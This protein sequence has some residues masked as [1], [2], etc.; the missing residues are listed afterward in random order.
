MPAFLVRFSVALLASAVAV[1]ATAATVDIPFTQRTLDNGLR[2]IVHEDRKAPIVAVNVWYHVGSKDEAPG[3]TGFAHLFEHLMFN[4]SE[5]YDDEYFLPFAQVG[6]TDQ[7]GTTSFDRTN[8]FQTVP[9]TALDLALW[10]ES[11]R[12]G[13]LLGAVTQEEL[14]TQRG[15]VQNEK[16]QGENEPYGRAFEYITEGVFPEGHPYSWLPIGSMEDISAASL[17]DVKTWFETYYGPN[18]AVLVIAGDVD[19]EEAFAKAEKFFGDIEPGPPLA[20]H[21]IW[22]P[23]LDGISRDV[24]ED[25]VKEARVYKVWTGPEWTNADADTLGLVASVLGSG[26]NSRLYKRLVYDDQIATGVSVSPLFLE[27]AG[28]IIVSATVSQTSSIEE[29]EAAIDEE[30]ARFIERGPT[31]EELKRVRTQS[32]ASFV[33]GVEK[34]GGFSGKS[35]ILAENAVYAGDPDFYKVSLERVEAATRESLREAA[36]R[37]MPADRQYVLEI[38]PH[39]EGLAAATEGADRSKLPLP[40]TFPTSRFDDYE[41]AELDNGLKLL[42]ARRDAVPVVQMQ[43]LLDAGYAADQFAPAGTSS[44]AMA[45]LDEGTSSRDALEISDELGQLGARLGTGSNIDASFVSLNTLAS[46][47][48]AALDIFTDVVLNPTFPEKELERLRKLRA[49]AIEREKTQP[50]SMALRV[51]PKL[52]YGEDHAYGQPLTGN[53]T[54]GSLAEITRATLVEYHNQWFRPNNAT[55]VV[56]GD[57]TLDEIRDKIEDRFGDWQRGDVPQKNIGTVA[58]RP[59]EEVYIVD[60]PGSIQSVILGGHVSPPK[61]NPNEFG[62]QAMNDILGGDFTSR[63]NMNLREDKDWAYGAYT[64]FISTRG[65]R[66]FLA[67]APVQSDKTA[68]SMRELKFEVERMLGEKPATA[69]ELE[70][71][72]N[73]A[74]LSL[75]GRWETAGSVAGSL[76]EMVRFGLPDDYWSTFAEQVRGVTLDDV[77]KAAEAV[78]RPDNMIWVVVGDR[79]TIEADIRALG[80]DEIRVIDA[81]G[82]P[83]DGE[84]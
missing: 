40:E 51:L 50:V 4:G 22:I 62:I 63:V 69:E 64:L 52:M 59:R 70:R 75:P 3:K 42:V 71:V 16:R 6:A 44:L 61:A 74:T 79:E 14:E 81:N 25:R 15:V 7:N 82:N 60:R 58:Q 48:D 41:R 10:M 9:T 45:M 23:T 46:E 29:V 54:Q 49:A 43:L 2:V 73:Q 68:D 32:L 33:R 53:G 31:R 67:Y 27:I 78:L 19:T 8:Y 30:L 65:Q 28:A 35:N 13:H 17:D 21:K 26:K 38:H 18:N 84:S 39:P 83:V 24:L 55:L 1:T 37:W 66:P 77:G 20:R 80:Y 47:L 34:V 12:M 11:D 72:R 56:V 76:S 5:N 57:V 36:Q